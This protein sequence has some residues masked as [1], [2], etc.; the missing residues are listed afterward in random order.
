MAVK[1]VHAAISGKVQGVCYR[2]WTVET[3]ANLG[4]DGW[5]R[6]CRN[7]TVEAVF[8]GEESAIEQMLHTCKDGP[9]AAMVHSIDVT[10][11]DTLPEAGFKQLPTV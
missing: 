3:A 11:T 8:S 6:N 9:P 5:V 4:I 7:G 10:V 2:A 1:T